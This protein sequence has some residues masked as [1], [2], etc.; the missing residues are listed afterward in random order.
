MQTE[1][2]YWKQGSD[3]IEEYHA[4]VMSIISLFPKERR[5]QVEKMMSGP[6]GEQFMTSPASTRR[7]FHYAFPCGLVAHSLNVVKYAVKLAETL[8][9]GRW[10]QWKV[11]FCALFHDLG[12][13]GSPGKPYY[14]P[15]KEEWKRK[16]GE[17]YDVSKDE[18]MPNAEK[19]LFVLQLNGVVLDHEETLAIRLNDGMGSE[20]NR[21]YSFNEPLLS[22][23]I[24]WADHFASRVEKEEG[25]GVVI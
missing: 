13:S 5:E 22:L 1:D 14:I 21:E 17:Y 7:N 25:T 24:H 4:M 8:A 20:S 2:E 11:M 10:P 18:W 6:T 23:V 9:P 15:T 16:R 3:K 12:K 19:S